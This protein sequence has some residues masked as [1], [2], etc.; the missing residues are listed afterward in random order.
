M[1]L[2]TALSVKILQL[3]KTFSSLEQQIRGCSYKTEDLLY[4]VLFFHYNCLAPTNDVFLSS[5]DG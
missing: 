1:D 3:N 5:D 2:E 4:N